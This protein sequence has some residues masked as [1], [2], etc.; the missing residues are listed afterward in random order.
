MKL[1]FL[2]TIVL[3][4]P[5]YLNASSYLCSTEQ[6]TG[7]YY[8]KQTEKLETA[9]FRPQQWLLK[10]LH[11]EDKKQD[12]VY[13]VYDSENNAFLFG[14]KVW[15]EE[16]EIA[17]CGNENDYH[18]KFGKHKGAYKFTTADLGIE[19]LLGSKSANARVSVG[20]CIKI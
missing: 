7:I 8:N 13:G 3:I 16:Y 18:F 10:P 4:T 9:N 6:S 1:K 14:C 5:F 19:L 17:H 2:L 11:E 15:F 20:N 12:Q